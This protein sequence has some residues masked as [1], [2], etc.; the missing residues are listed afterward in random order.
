MHAAEG[1]ELGDEEIARI[2]QRH[3]MRG[4]N[5]PRFPLRRWNL[6]RADA[7]LGVRSHAR[8]DSARFVEQ[9]D[10]AGEL[11][12]YRVIAGA[13]RNAAATSARAIFLM[14]S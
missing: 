5:Q 6:V 2:V 12:N 9:R 7:L 3:A 10:A 14:A 13:S 4:T 1:V 8:G 11:A